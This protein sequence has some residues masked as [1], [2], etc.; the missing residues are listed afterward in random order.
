MKQLSKYI[1]ERLIINKNFKS[2]SN[3]GYEEP[4][5]DV[6]QL[7][8]MILHEYAEMGQDKSNHYAYIDEDSLNKLHKIFENTL[9]GYDITH[10]RIDDIE[11]LVK[12][13]VKELFDEKY[14]I[15]IYNENETSKKIAEELGDD[16][17]FD[18]L[19]PTP[20]S[21]KFDSTFKYYLGDETAYMQYR[22]IWGGGIT[23][24]S[25]DFDIF[26]FKF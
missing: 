11:K 24:L 8:N 14:V 17:F 23:R 4:S 2:A 10:K 3:G 1:E 26:I 13:V 25:G 7:D 15:H 16:N 20:K 18:L 12:Y 6:K 22:R 5:G 9:G 19:P 21:T